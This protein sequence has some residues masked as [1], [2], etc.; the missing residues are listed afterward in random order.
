MSYPWLRTARA[1]FTDRLAADRLAHAILLQGPAGTGKHA[2]AMDMAARLLCNEPGDR[3]CGQCRSCTLFSTGAHPDWFPLAPEEGKHQ[4]V[5]DAVRETARA[6]TFTTTISDRKVA[7]ISPA[8][9]MNVNAANALLKTLE[10]PPGEATIILV[11]HD[12]SRLPV[13]IR[14]RC[15]AITVTLPERPEALQWLQE[16][17]GL[18]EQDARAA[19]EAAGGSPLRAAHYACEGLVAGHQELLH[20]LAGLLRNPGQASAVAA[21]LGEVEPET[22]WYWRS[23]AAA[24]AV[25]KMATGQPVDWLGELQHHRPRELGLLQQSADRNR[26]LARTA[27][28]QDLLLEE[29]LI[30]WAALAV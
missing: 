5:I 1:L 26:R 11:A 17:E 27:V 10:E 22:L 23:A 14:S 19:L 3:A 25:R 4:I 20:S 18:A 12:P 16:S 2:L 24:E 29:W 7:L 15:Q 6:L 28:R 21:Q 13:T 30:E 8:E 9:A